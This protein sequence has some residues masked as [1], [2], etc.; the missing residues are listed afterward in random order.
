MGLAAELRAEADALIEEYGEDVEWTHKGPGRYNFATGRNVQ[1]ATDK[2]RRVYVESCRRELRQ[3]VGVDAG[4]LLLIGTSTS[5][6][7]P[8][9]VGDDCLRRT[10]P[11][12][13]VAFNENA[14]EGEPVT[15][16]IQARQT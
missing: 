3:G 5:F 10:I 16:D 15:Y 8:P 1:S 11:Y 6:T 12:S 2:E 9:A 4:D 7:V 13:V 14:V